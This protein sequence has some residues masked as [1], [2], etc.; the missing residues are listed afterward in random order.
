M[1]ETPFDEAGFAAKLYVT[2]REVQATAAKLL[3]PFGVTPH[4][5]CVLYQLDRG[6]AMPSR[7][8]ALMGI[9]AS[10]M[11]RI[12]QQ[13]EK[14]KLI[15]RELDP[16][17][18]TRTIVSLTA[19]GR[20]MN[21]RITWHADLVQEKIHCSLSESDRAALNRCLHRILNAMADLRDAA[22]REPPCDSSNA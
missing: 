9:D 14:Q 15:Q 12:L 21:R 22:D 18:R 16:D 10:S 11:S 17:N 13:L 3:A 20:S 5:A 7:I 4:Q 8:A 6:K 19:E 1:A 2:S